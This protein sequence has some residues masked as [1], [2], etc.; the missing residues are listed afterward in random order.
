MR[1]SIIPGVPDFR[2][3]VVETSS[4]VVDARSTGEKNLHVGPPC[5]LFELA[6]GVAQAESVPVGDGFF[7]LLICK[8][9]IFIGLDFLLEW[10]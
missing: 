10:F 3:C 5:L 6:T 9:E 4:C 8:G 2:W 7:N 1:G